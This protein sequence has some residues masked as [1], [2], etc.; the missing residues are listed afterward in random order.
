MTEHSEQTT[1][2]HA[3]HGPS[4]HDSSI[5]PPELAASFVSFAVLCVVLVRLLRAPLANYFKNHSSSVRKAIE[6]ATLLKKAAERKH[7]EYEARIKNLD[8]EMEHMRAELIRAGEKERDRVLSEAEHRA[9]RMR[10]DVQFIISQSVKQL[11][12]RL[13]QE[14][15][16]KVMDAAYATLKGQ[17]TSSDHERLSD[18]FLDHLKH[19]QV[20]QT[21]PQIVG[22]GGGRISSLPT[23][24]TS[25]STAL[26]GGRSNVGNRVSGQTTLSSTSQE[27]L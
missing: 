11:R 2:A 8:A 14:T 9:A 15:S 12:E 23:A 17:L 1:S 3:E 26:S 24:Y 4:G 18:A 10:A 21:G 27:D 6:E 20:S 13:L 5:N 19:L 7:A 22:G 25:R 16:I